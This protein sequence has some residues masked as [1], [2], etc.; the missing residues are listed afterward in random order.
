MG[1]MAE[2]MQP[3][4]ATQCSQLPTTCSG[5]HHSVDSNLVSGTVNGGRS[6]KPISLENFQEIL[7]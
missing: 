5:G 4:K 3:G 1:F 2:G 6:G 7:S